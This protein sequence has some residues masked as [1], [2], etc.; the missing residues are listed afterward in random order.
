MIVMKVPLLKVSAL[1]EM[2]AKGCSSSLKKW[3]KG[4]LITC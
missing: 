3:Q 1:G 4:G 2:K